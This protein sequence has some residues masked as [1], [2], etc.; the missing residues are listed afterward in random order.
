M[1]Q[2]TLY[3]GFF[4]NFLDALDGSYCTNVAY[5]ETSNNP[6]LDPPYPD[7]RPGGLNGSLQCGVF[8]PT[9]VISISYSGQ[10][11]D[12]PPNYQRRQCFEFLKLGLQGV[13]VV[14]S[15]GDSGVGGASGTKNDNTCLGDNGTIFSP[16]FPATCPFLTVVGGTVLPVGGS[17]VHDGEIA[18]TR[19]SSGG[20]FSNIYPAPEYQWATRDTYFRDSSPPYPYYERLDSSSRWASSGVYNRLGRGYPDVAAVADNILTFHRGHPQLASGT[21]AGVPIFAAILNRINEERLRANKST[22]GF[23]NPILVSLVFQAPCM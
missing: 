7:S 19:F 18:A 21:S 15:S 17:V 22:V 11:A 13:S 3:R 16:S 6:D 10:E 1:N 12:F 2:N 8:T 20:G 9:N 23:V 5:N 4:N 14:V